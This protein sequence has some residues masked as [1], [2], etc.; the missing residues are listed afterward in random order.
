MPC[1]NINNHSDLNIEKY[2]SHFDSFIPYTQKVLGY[3]K[4]FTLNL[5]SDPENSQRALG[6]TAFYDPNTFEV[7]IY[8]DGRHIKD[9]MRS[10]A[11]ELVHHTQN[12][13]GEFEGGVATDDGYAQGNDHLR[14]M[15]REAYEKGNMLFRD[16]ED[17]Y[18][19]VYGENIMKTKIKILRENNIIN[20]EIHQL[21][22]L[23]EGAW[24]NLVSGIKKTM[25]Y[26]KKVAQKVGG[27]AFEKAVQTGVGLGAAGALAGA[28]TG[29]SAGAIGGPIGMAMGA[30][31]GGLSGASMGTG[32]GALVGAQGGALYGFYDSIGKG[33]FKLAKKL[34]HDLSGEEK[35]QANKDAKATKK[36]SSKKSSRRKC[37]KIL[38]RGCRGDNVK[39]LQAKL[40][41]LGYTID[42]DGA[43]GPGTA[44][45]V[46]QFQGDVELKVDGIAGP[47]TLRK[48]NNI[49]VIKDPSKSGSE[50]KTDDVAAD[51]D[52]VPEPEMDQVDQNIVAALKKRLAFAKRLYQQSHDLTTKSQIDV[53]EDILK[54]AER[55]APMTNTQQQQLQNI[56]KDQTAMTR[57]LKEVLAENKKKVNSK[58][59]DDLVKAIKEGR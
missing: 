26:G 22:I 48:L 3:D 10:I 45:V 6:R 35:E 38:K 11:H 57:S 21:N 15:E 40:K 12:C 1:K 50:K 55:G 42:V 36:G 24:D 25:S 32:A 4:Q 18:K 13:R 33:N 34:W 54:D 49:E 31:I 30:I 2:K 9:I 44:G 56:V 20:E 58:K 28:A 14:G 43:Y 59:F 8:V 29:A 23:N 7:T 37:T 41:E 39:A 47:D 16:W 19:R 27:D 51:A 5:Q 17:G 53:L 46:K 52:F